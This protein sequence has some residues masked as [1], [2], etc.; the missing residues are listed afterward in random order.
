MLKQLKL[1]LLYQKANSNI[2]IMA[3]WAL[4]KFVPIVRTFSYPN[5]QLRMK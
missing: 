1:L 4:T 3:T 5:S 2:R